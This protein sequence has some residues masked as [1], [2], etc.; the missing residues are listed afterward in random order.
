MDVHV[1]NVEKCKKTPQQSIQF[2]SSASETIKQNEID[3]TMID[4]F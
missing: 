1:Q 4:Y 3:M 2:V